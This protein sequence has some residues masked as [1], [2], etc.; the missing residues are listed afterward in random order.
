VHESEESAMGERSRKARKVRKG[1]SRPE[2]EAVVIEIEAP[3]A[4]VDSLGLEGFSRI[5]VTKT[6]EVIEVVR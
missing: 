2:V 5:R 3:P 4:T 1:A 6:R